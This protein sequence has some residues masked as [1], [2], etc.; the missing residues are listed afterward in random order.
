MLGNSPT[1]LTKEEEE[2]EVKKYLLNYKEFL[3]KVKQESLVNEN[4]PAA[5]AASPRR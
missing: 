4:R 1:V 2:E 5:A 3:G